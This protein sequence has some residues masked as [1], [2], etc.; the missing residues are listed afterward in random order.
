MRVSPA[1]LAAMSVTD[2]RTPEDYEALIERRALEARG[3]SLRYRPLEPQRA[4]RGVG[5]PLSR[6]GHIVRGSLQLTYVAERFGMEVTFPEAHSHSICVVV[7]LMGTVH[8]EPYGKQ[9]PRGAA[10]GGVILCQDGPG[11][12]GITRDKTE[13]LNLRIDSRALTRRLQAMLEQPLVAPLEFG[14]VQDGQQIGVRSLHRL[15]V[16]MADEMADPTSFLA[17]GT[18][19]AAFEEM[20]I[21]TLL[22]GVR[23]NYTEVL[24]RRTPAASGHAVQR[25]IGFMRENLRRPLTVEEIAAAAGCAPRALSKEFTKRQGRTLSTALQD[26]RL[27]AAREALLAGSAA[28]IVTETARQFGFSNAGRFISR[29]RARFGETP[30]QTRK[31]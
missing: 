9:T 3:G 8:F 4:R 16:M 10:A 20:L 19:V 22:E 12:R 6:F 5:S 27:G 2:V 18:G 25:A 21:R 29:Y 11:A 23:H 17:Q 30:N 28:G 26:F 7:P 31:S 14:A 13:R 15:V 1:L 24:A